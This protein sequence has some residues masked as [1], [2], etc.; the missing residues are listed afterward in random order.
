LRHLNW[1]VDDLSDRLGVG[2][3]ETRRILS[4]DRPIDADLAELLAHTLGGSSDFWLERENQ[5]AESVRALSDDEFAQTL[6]L[7]QMIR[8]GWIESSTSWRSQARS[9]LEFFGA[10]TPSEGTSRIEGTLREAR[11]RASASFDSDAVTLATWMRQVERIASTQA[12]ALWNPGVLSDQL[13]HLRA[14]SRLADPAEFLPQVGA[15]LAAAG[16][17]LVVLRPLEGM[18][19]SGV[20]FWSA[21]R[22]PIVALTARHMTDDHLWFTLFH[23]IGHLLLHPE[24]DV[25]VDEFDTGQD[26][27]HLEQEAN[28][29]AAEALLP[30]GTSEIQ[31]KRANGPTLRE[32]AR[33]SSRHAIAPG[34]VVGQ[35]QH[36]GVLRPNQLN[37]L[38]RRYHWNGSELARRS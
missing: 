6:P 25:F 8:R 23:E 31:S 20:S 36:S 21:E 17:S 2:D 1:T 18:R 32:V 5:F 30:F 34:V 19:V 15:S 29:F 10:D 13:H 22:A 16:V 33:F 7:K 24:G 12:P 9:A 4:G 38:K 14:L 3:P 27:S 35:L 28:V 37:G 26:T 11:Y